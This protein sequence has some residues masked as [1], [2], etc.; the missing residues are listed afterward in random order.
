[1]VK[2]PSVSPLS[3]QYSTTSAMH[4]WPIAF[5]GQPASVHFCTGESNGN[6]KGTKYPSLQSMTASDRLRLFLV[7]MSSL[8]CCFSWFPL[9]FNPCGNFSDTSGFKSWITKGSLGHSFKVCIITGNQNQESFYPYV[10]HE[11][12]VLIE[13]PLGHLCC[14]LTNVPPQPNSPPDNVFNLDFGARGQPLKSTTRKWSIF[15]ESVGSN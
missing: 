11:I 8:F 14:L 5:I 1:M 2:I 4:S 6:G 10:Q 7:Y 13:L 15:K 9:L 3:S 12:S